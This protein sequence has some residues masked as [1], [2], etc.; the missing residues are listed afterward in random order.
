MFNLLIMERYCTLNSYLSIKINTHETNTDS[1]MATSLMFKLSSLFEFQLR[2]WVEQRHRN[3]G[4]FPQF[5]DFRSM[6]KS[7]LSNVS[8]QCITLTLILYELF[9]GQYFL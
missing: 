6:L 3:S 9:D 2:N 5:G 1:S 8:A 7:I 4:P